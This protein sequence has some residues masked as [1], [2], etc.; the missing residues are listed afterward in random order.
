MKPGRHQ[1]QASGSIG[2]SAQSHGPPT[3]LRRS[4][5]QADRHFCEGSY[6]CQCPQPGCLLLS[7]LVFWS[8]LAI[9]VCAKWGAMFF[10]SLANASHWCT[11]GKKRNNQESLQDGDRGWDERRQFFC[12]LF[13][14]IR[15]SGISTHLEGTERNTQTAREQAEQ[16]THVCRYL[17]VKAILGGSGWWLAQP[18]T[19]ASNPLRDGSS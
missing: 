4:L 5:A 13:N 14:L 9:Q 16:S 1:A 3:R 18:R 2:S 8:Y 6:A 15:E 7:R 11:R 12:H 10:F 19:K 17:V